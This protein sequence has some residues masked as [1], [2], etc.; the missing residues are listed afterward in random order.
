MPMKNGRQRKLLMCC[1][2]N[3]AWTDPRGRRDFG[4]GG[5]SALAR[6]RVRGPSMAAAAMDESNAFSMIAVPAWM[7]CGFACPPVQA[8]KV[9]HLLSDAV[10]KVVSPSD[11][12]FLAYRRLPMGLAHAVHILMSINTTHIH[13]ILR[14]TARRL[15]PLATACEWDGEATA[16]DKRWAQVQRRR[17][18]ASIQGV[19]PRSRGGPGL[20]DRTYRLLRRVRSVTLQT[21]VILHCFAGADRAGRSYPPDGARWM[22]R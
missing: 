14:T 18:G 13:R 1:A 5:G 17:R 11:D 2:T 19:G 10:K 16:P 3:Y 6:A 8:A 22:E 15:A 20:L 9:W 7:V 21:V 4:L 12:V